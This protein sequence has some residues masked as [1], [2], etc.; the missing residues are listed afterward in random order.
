M[1]RALNE[2]AREIPPQ[3]EVPEEPVGA[4]T[5][6][7][8]VLPRG[9]A[10][11]GATVPQRRPRRGEPRERPAARPAPAAA[12]RP[13]RARRGSRALLVLVVVLL[14]AAAAVAAIVATAPGSTKVVLRNV[15]YS[16]IHKSTQELKRLVDQNTR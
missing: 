5:R 8:N 1:R 15:V 7:T 16:D 4:P 10:V 2:G 3:R 14:I 13:R 9:T 12:A 11:A 6:A